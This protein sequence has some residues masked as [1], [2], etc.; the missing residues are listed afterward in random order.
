[1]GDVIIHLQRRHQRKVED[2]AHNVFCYV[3]F[4]DKSKVLG[5]DNTWDPSL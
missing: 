2:P 5:A 1:M 3:L 4:R